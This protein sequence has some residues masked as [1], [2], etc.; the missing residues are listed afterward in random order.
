VAIVRKRLELDASRYQILQI[1]SVTPFEKTPILQALQHP[2]TVKEECLSKLILFGEGTLRQALTEFCEHYHTERNHQGKRT[3]SRWQTVTASRDGI[4][5]RQRLGGL[6][7][8]YA[9]AA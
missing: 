2:R 3:S 7:K 9:R 1:L 8:S 5:C 4:R 6:L